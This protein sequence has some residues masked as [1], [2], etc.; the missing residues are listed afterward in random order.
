MRQAQGP[1]RAERTY[2]TDINEAGR[3]RMPDSMVKPLA[4]LSQPR[5]PARDKILWARCNLWT[6][7][8]KVLI[9]S[10]FLTASIFP[11]FLLSF[12]C[13]SL[14]RQDERQSRL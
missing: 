5:D 11:S 9:S 13:L 7:S 10:R 8:F 6:L 1:S 4:V 12:L 3:T 14:S 2:N